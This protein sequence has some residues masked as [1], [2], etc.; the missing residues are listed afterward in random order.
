M[1]KRTIFRQ[2]KFGLEYAAF[3]AVIGIVRLFPL[4]T[5]VAASARILRVAAA[6]GR[7]QRRVLSN[8]QLAFPALSDG[9]REQIAFRMWENLGRVLAEAIHQD[10]IL[11]DPSRFEIVDQGVLDRYRSDTNAQIYVSLHT[12]NWE[13][14]IA[15]VTWAG[16][17]PAAVYRLIKNPYVDQYVRDSRKL[18]F[19][20]GFFAKGEQ[21]EMDEAT[22]PTVRQIVGYIRKGGRLCILADNYDDQGIPVPFFGHPAKST[23][24]PALL[25]RQT[26]CRLWM[27]RCVRIG[28]TSRFRIECMEMTV[29]H[30]DDRS[31][32]VRKITADIQKQFEDWIRE[33]PDQWAWYHRKWS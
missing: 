3:R 8:L 7:R 16:Y 14:G 21:K 33:Y 31:G 13:L 1:P 22:H 17:H 10:R 6:R 4:D 11:S 29:H 20:G 5:A 15:P 27:G 28:T 2:I 24:Y 18:L 26:G 25:A 12:G 19:P 30:T 23:P 32:D 9:E